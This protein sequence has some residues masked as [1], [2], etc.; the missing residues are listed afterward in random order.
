MLFRSEKAFTSEFTVIRRKGVNLIAI[1]YSEYYK[2]KLTEAATLL[3]D[4]AEDADNPSLKKYLTTRAAAFLSNDYF[5]SDMNWMDVKDNDIE[6]VIGP[7]EV[8][9]DGMFNYKTS[10]ESFLT[11]RDPVESE[12][13]DVFKKY[14]KDMELNLPIPDRKSTRLNSSHT[15]ISRMPSSA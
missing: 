11:I 14:L 1:P 12:K 2:D 9:E 10:F 5:E 8:Y 4:A 7:Y 15:D 13:L 3:L 6:I